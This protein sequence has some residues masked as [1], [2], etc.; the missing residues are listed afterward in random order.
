VSGL[1]CHASGSRIFL[2]L[3]YGIMPYRGCGG[4]GRA[5]EERAERFYQHSGFIPFPTIAGRL[6]IVMKT[7]K[8]LFP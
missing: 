2:D 3:V 1:A 6:F 8:Q 5:I 7:V 4:C